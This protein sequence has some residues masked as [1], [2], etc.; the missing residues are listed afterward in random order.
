MNRH[1]QTLL[2]YYNMELNYDIIISYLYPKLKD[3]NIEKKI[4][5]MENIDTK[6]FSNIF[7]NNFY[8]Y[9]VYKY[10]NNNNNISLLM[11]LLYCLDEK[12]INYTEDDINNISIHYHKIMKEFNLDTFV[13]T[14]DM[15]FFIFNYQSGDIS[16]GYQG[17][18][19]NP[20]KPSIFLAYDNIFYEPI[21]SNENRLFNY[22]MSKNNILKSYILFEDIKYFNNSKEFVINDNINEVLENNNLMQ[23]TISDTFITTLDISKN[24]SL[25]KLNK[26]RKTELINLLNDLNLSIQLI[27][28][29]KKDIINIICNNYDIK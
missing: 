9:G 2:L 13:N 29:T 18:Y 20:W 12:Y 6:Y 17:D 10:D 25:N 26:M 1:K 11:S 5:I 14:F 23:N 27:K 28:P 24:I 7:N 21:I 15:N 19:M 4:N 16:I 8:K 22:S 3:D